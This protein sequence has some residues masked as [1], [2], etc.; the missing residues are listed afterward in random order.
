[1][2]SNGFGSAL[3]AWKQLLADDQVIDDTASLKDAQK[4]TF[5]YSAKVLAILYPEKEQLAECLG[6][7]RQHNQKLY[8]VSSGKNW[9]YG[10][11]LPVSEDSVILNLGRLKKISNYDQKNGVVTVEAGV[12]QAELAAFLKQQGDHHWMDCTGSSA[13]CNSTCRSLNSGS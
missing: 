11:Q 2:P 3:S 4:A 6:I 10:S 5:A 12:T 7:A 9:G 13:S 8:T 1:M